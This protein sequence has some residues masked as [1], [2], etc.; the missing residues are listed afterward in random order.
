M[1]LQDHLSHKLIYE[2]ESSEQCGLE[3]EE[4]TLHIYKTYEYEV[5]GDR[6]WCQT[7]DPDALHP[8]PVPDHMR[9]E[10]HV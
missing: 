8:M 2:L 9:I 5:T 7:C 3:V 6:I 10:W 4:D 1:T